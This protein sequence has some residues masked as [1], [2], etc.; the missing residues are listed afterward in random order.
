[1]CCYQYNYVI[2]D[3]VGI[4]ILLAFVDHIQVD[5]KFMSTSKILRNYIQEPFLKTLKLMISWKMNA[6]AVIMI[7]DGYS[8]AFVAG[9]FSKV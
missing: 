4:I 2:F 5:K 6:I 1:M 9:L 3:V 8:I 7:V